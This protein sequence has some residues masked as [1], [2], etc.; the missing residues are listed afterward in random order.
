MAVETP[1]NIVTIINHKT[2]PDMPL[3]A[4][5]VASCSIPFL[6]EPLLD[7]KEWKYKPNYNEN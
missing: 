2:R 4:A 1:A 3:W 7:R 5:I 6:F